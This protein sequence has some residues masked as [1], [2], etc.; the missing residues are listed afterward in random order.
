MPQSNNREES[1]AGKP[2]VNFI[3]E[4]RLQQRLQ[5][6]KREI[7]T[8]EEKVALRKQN[9]ERARHSIGKKIVEEFM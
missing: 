2:S 3:N 1:H 4:N 7:Y 5:Q 9:F 6:I 8:N